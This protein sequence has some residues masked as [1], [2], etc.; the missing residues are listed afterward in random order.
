M[1]ALLGDEKNR[2]KIQ[3]TRTVDEA[4]VFMEENGFAYTDEQK[5]EIRKRAGELASLAKTRELTPEDLA[6][7]AGGRGIEDPVHRWGISATF[8]AP[9]ILAG[10]GVGL[11][12]AT[13]VGWVV[14]AGIA[15]GGTAAV[16]AF[17]YTMLGD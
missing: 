11:F 14:A 3:S 4:I 12:A 13:P 5:E 8:S 6:S 16:A 9:M 2:E 10:V 15:V 7:A 17:S 1:D